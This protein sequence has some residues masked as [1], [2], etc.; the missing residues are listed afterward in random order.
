[1]PKAPDATPR[2]FA[3]GDVVRAA[4]PLPFDAVYDYLVGPDMHLTVGQ[5]V[6][7]PLGKRFET[8]VV[9]GEGGGDV[10][11]ERLKPIAAVEAVRPL[12]QAHLDFL[13]WVAD[14][15]VQ[16]AG[17]V[18][19]MGIAGGQRFRPPKPQT[20]YRLTGAD[21]ETLGLRL[22]DAR[23][24]VLAVLG[25]AR[26]PL[27]AAEVARQADCSPGVISGLADA[28]ALSQMDIAPP[29]PFGPPDPDLPGPHL[30]PAQ[31]AAA[32]ALK[33]A[34]RGGFQPFV[35]HGVTG[36]GKTEV[37]LEAAAET[38]RA[39]RQVLI[40]LPEIALTEQ[41]L[42][43]IAARFGTVPA[44]WHSDVPGA[45][46]RQIWAGV[47]DG[48][49]RFVIGARS[50]LFLPFADL[51][52]IIVDE[53]HDSAFKQ[54]D[55]VFYN[56]RDMAVVRARIGNAP[57]VL[58]SATPSL[59]TLHN[60]QTGKYTALIL[61]ERHGGALL[62]EVT[63][64]DLRETPPENGDWGRGWLAPPLVGAIAETLAA[65]EQVLLFLNRRGY[66]PLTICKSCGHRMAC[67]NCS[68]WLVEHRFTHRLHCHHC[69]SS[70]PK[71]PACPSCGEI[72]SLIPCGPGVERIAEEVAHRF[73][74]ARTAIVSTDTL[75]SPAAM[76]DLIAAVESGRI[77]LLIGTQMLAKGHH[78]PHLT[79][80]GVVDA[81]M[82]L[83]GWELRAAEQTFQ[84][85][86]QV[87]GRAGRTAGRPGRVMI[88][89]HQP[90]HPV[91]AAIAAHDQAAF[92]AAEAADRE[93]VGM[94]PF[95]RLAALILSGY[96]EKEVRAVGEHLAAT[97]PTGPG[98]TVLGP[99]PAIMA[100]LRG[101]HRYRMLLRA[102]RT[103]RLQPMIRDWLA[104]VKIPSA[105][106]VQVDIDPQSFF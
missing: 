4:L 20:G 106:R 13:K 41:S 29:S 46:K 97:A 59:E 84:T 43:R 27:T 103:R 38:L 45:L 24:K 96:D 80:V 53:E 15:T 93:S 7:V 17:S 100:L 58:A 44:V 39:G 9:L 76:A 42:A 50:A 67:D 104:M 52:L 68:A 66:A 63:L 12:P 99:A 36:S 6:Q 11:P 83:T 26:G 82:G 57:V 21:P 33:T 102:D 2:L 94:P 78:F 55:G 32:E 89:T 90:D 98:L 28:G 8:A 87:A 35:L 19:R 69:G 75:A 30:S 40:L 61:P 47:L 31:A 48:S 85:L 88:Q 23:K 73:P 65:R 64:V 101:R 37:Y 3:P 70:Q 34:V 54:E 71:P 91:I 105:V 81:D 22:T 49:A 72:D 16:P 10:D 60:A 92:A 18:L 25:A 79:L 86:S 5:L 62:P 74:N 1:M 95:G 14:Y 77:N 51:G 56:A